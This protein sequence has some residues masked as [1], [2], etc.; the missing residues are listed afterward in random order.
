[1]PQTIDLTEKAKT[2]PHFE[3]MRQLSMK[4]G[5]KP[6]T[7]GAAIS[8]G[9]LSPSLAGALARELGEDAISWMAIAGLEADKPSNARDQMLKTAAE[10][11]TRGK[12]RIFPQ[13]SSL[14]LWDWCAT[15]HGQRS[16]GVRAL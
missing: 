4:L 13:L 2:L 8:R 15:W 5:F 12:S 14:R 10:W 1:M 11:V 16:V 6:T 9:H 7:L 3:S